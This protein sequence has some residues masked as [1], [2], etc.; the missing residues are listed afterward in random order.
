[1]FFINDNL[2]VVT[3]EVKVLAGEDKGKFICNASKKMWLAD[4]VAGENTGAYKLLTLQEAARGVPLKL[5]HFVA[6]PFD[7]EF[8]G[9]EEIV[10]DFEKQAAIALERIGNFA[11]ATFV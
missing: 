5:L 11:E 3:E 7:F 8:N 4:S 6:V 10:Q 9:Q 2:F 1:M